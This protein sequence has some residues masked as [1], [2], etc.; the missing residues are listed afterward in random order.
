[1]TWPEFLHVVEI[2]KKELEDEKAN[3]LLLQKQDVKER[4]KFEKAVERKK[5]KVATIY[6]KF[7][8]LS[9]FA[10]VPDR[11]RTFRELQIGKTFT[12]QKESSSDG[13]FETLWVIK[14]GPDD[15]KT[16]KSYGVRPLLLLAPYLTP[17]IDEFVDEYR[18]TLNPVNDNKYFFL[19]VIIDK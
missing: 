4:L 17:Y 3:L 5:R 18:P 7:L 19:Q 12:K 10:C 8:M 2:L 16:G 13:N 1:M 9:F 14:H 6:Q 11:Q 15:Y